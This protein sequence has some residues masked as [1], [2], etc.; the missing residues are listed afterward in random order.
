[1][2]AWAVLAGV[3]GAVCTMGFMQGLYLL[4]EWIAGQHGSVVGVMQALPWWARVLLP[5]AGGVAAGGLLWLAARGQTATHSDYME[6]VAIGDGRLPVRQGLLRSA[7]SLLTVASGGSIGREGAMVH[8]AAMASATVGRFTQ[9]GMAR[10]RLMV[11]CGAAAGLSAAYGAPLA[12]AL[13]VAEIVLGSMAVRSVGPLLVA[14]G[15]SHLVMRLSGS[16]HTVYAVP[17]LDAVSLSVLA[18]LLPLGVLAGMGAPAFLRLLDGAKG[19]FRRTGLA[20]PW[21]LGLGGLLLGLLLLVY[22]ESSGNGYSVVQRMLSDPWMWQAVVLMLLVK[23]AATSLTV[24]SG[25][26]GGVFTPVLFVGAAIGM[27]YGQAVLAL[28]PALGVPPALFVLVGMGALLGAATGAPLMAIL[29]LFE[30][31]QEY[32]LVLPLMFACVVAYVVSR[33]LSEAVMYGVTRTREQDAR[34]RFE[35]GR[36]TL[37]SLI[38]A[39]E[40]VV[41]LSAPVQEAARMFMEIP[42]RY[43]YVVDDDDVYQ[44]VIAQQDLTGLLMGQGVVEEKTV[45]D[46]VR[47]DFVRPLHP[48]MTLDQAQ[49]RFVS[50]LGERLPVVARG[51]RA[52]LLGVVYKSTL[53]ENY[54]RIK[55]SLGSSGDGLADDWYGAGRNGPGRR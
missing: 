34:L 47:R 46:M 32:H 18:A 41:R 38:R 29:M 5:A 28:W 14:A 13:F 1:M 42:V 9:F 39:P 49:E 17:A 2:L 6:A 10:L 15:T 43:L 24:G 4:Q 54:F 8:L 16:Y 23:L 53:L 52:V 55:A 44:G 11:A 50:F 37:G 31:T 36:A 35:L 27:L 7:S 45:G 51:E 30:M 40:T 22:P 20:L 19:L 3:M 21:R 12:G 33:S 48:D 25:A 26:V